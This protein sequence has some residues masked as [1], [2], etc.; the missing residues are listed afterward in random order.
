M[1]DPETAGTIIHERGFHTG[2][3]LYY[4][5]VSY[6]SAA[7]T[8]SKLT[9]KIDECAT[10]AFP[11]VRRLSGHKAVV[12]CCRNDI[13]PLVELVNVHFMTCLL[14]TSDAADD[15]SEV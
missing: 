13:K 5:P 14:Y 10:A 2:N 9:N 11:V 3:W 15:T 1:P 6:V 8:P 7:I 4:E 12:V